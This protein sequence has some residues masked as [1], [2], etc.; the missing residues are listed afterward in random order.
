[1]AVLRATMFTIMF[2]VIAEFILYPLCHRVD[3]VTMC[4]VVA[5]E[6]F[7]LCMCVYVCV[8]W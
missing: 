3:R 6:K 5:K 8:M 4:R 7:T 2:T 1:M